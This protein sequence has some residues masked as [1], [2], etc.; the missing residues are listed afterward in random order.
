MTI[1]SLTSLL[2]KV[3]LTAQLRDNVGTLK[4]GVKCANMVCIGQDSPNN[5][6]L[7]FIAAILR[8]P[9]YKAFVP[10]LYV[11][12]LTENHKQKRKWLLS[13]SRS[14]KPSSHLQSAINLISQT[15]EKHRISKKATTLNARTVLLTRV[16]ARA[17]IF[18]R[19]DNLISFPPPT[20]PCARISFRLAFAATGLVATTLLAPLLRLGQ[21]MVA[22]PSR[23]L[24]T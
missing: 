16:R 15:Q 24:A 20:I 7:F 19:T 21:S 1:A 3:T 17:P 6:F 22:K 13:S 23:W 8:S 18:R 11:S 12:I 9:S 10:I 5:P 4:V 14:H 2:N